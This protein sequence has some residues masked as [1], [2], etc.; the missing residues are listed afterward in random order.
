MFLALMFFL[1]AGCDEGD[2][3]SNYTPTPTN[4]TMSATVKY[5][6]DGDSFEVY[7]GDKEYEVRT[8]GIDCFE[9]QEGERLNGQAQKAG[10]S[11]DSALSLAYEAKF[12]A[13]DMLK[14][15]EVDLYREPGVPN[16]DV[17]GRL[18]RIVVVEDTIR[19]DSLMLA[20]GLALPY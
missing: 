6:F 10:I 12:F 16:L 19:W 17:Y 3:I 15:K 13:I 8:L 1:L 4:D 18:L 2:R 14:N 9:T 11:I 5:V 7:Y 20:K